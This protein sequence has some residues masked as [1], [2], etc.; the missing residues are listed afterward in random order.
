MVVR[1]LNLVC[2]SIMPSEANSPLVVNP[3]AMLAGAM[4]GKFFQAVTRWN[5]KVI[6]PLGCVQ[7]DQ[8]I[9]RHAME[10]GWKAPRE[11]A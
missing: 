4:T 11:L 8:F 2:I 7:D 10:L 1:Y 9:P 3:N 6:Q 5:A